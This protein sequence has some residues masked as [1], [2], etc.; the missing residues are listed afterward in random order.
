MAKLNEL[1]KDLPIIG[2]YLRGDDDDHDDGDGGPLAAHSRPPAAADDDDVD[3]IPL[4]PVAM[5]DD[6]DDDNDDVDG[7]PIGAVAQFTRGARLRFNSR[8]FSRAQSR[9]PKHRDWH[10]LKHISVRKYR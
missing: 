2:E 1:L 5:A 6:D 3:G 10:E 8:F 4:A 9:R 7:V